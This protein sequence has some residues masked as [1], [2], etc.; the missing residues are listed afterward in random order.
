MDK[1]AAKKN[2]PLEPGQESD[3]LVMGWVLY[4]HFKYLQR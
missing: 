1:K 3:F 4:T 2:G